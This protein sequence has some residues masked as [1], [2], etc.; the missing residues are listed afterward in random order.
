MPMPHKYLVAL[1]TVLKWFCL[2]MYGVIGLFVVLTV[3]DWISPRWGYPL[4]LLVPL[5]AGL[6]IPYVMRKIAILQLQ[7]LQNEE[8]HIGPKPR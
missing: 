2:L 4:S 7:I 1:Y 3:V 8:C 5:A 6:V